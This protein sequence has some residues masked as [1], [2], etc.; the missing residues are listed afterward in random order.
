MKNL[1]SVR[2]RLSGAKLLGF[3]AGVVKHGIA[4]VG[5]A[6]GVVAKIGAPKT[7]SAKLGIV[8]KR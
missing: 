6:K 2:V 4:K 3:E 7:T 8:K 1:D 5:V